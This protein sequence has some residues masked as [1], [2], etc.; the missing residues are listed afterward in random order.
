MNASE[1]RAAVVVEPSF[2]DRLGELARRMHVWLVSTPE[3]EGLALR[4]NEAVA[5]ENEDSDLFESGVTV[6]DTECVAPEDQV[7]QGVFRRAEVR[8][9]SCSLAR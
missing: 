2:G 6:F 5:N 8:E 7:L 3:N 4:V 1:H 9:I